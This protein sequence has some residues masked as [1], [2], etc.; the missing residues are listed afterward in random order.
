MRGYNYDITTTSPWQYQTILYNQFLTTGTT[1]S[2]LSPLPSKEFSMRV[3]KTRTI[4][5]Y[6]AQAFLTI[7]GAEVLVAER[8][9][10]EGE[11]LD[12][13][14]EDLDPVELYV[15]DITDTLRALLA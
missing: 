5:G 10:E 14:G 9:Y 2:T 11:L 6:L 7:N 8:N 4:D 13:E 15:A 3:T 12:D 1:T